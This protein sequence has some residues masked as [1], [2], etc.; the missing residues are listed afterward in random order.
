M[1]QQKIGQFLRELRK[2]K[3][4][5]QEQLLEVFGVTNRSISRWENGVNM[6]DFDLVMEI[7][8][9][10]DVSIDELLDGEK[11]SDM[12]DKQTKETLLKVAAYDNNEKFI[13]SRRMNRLF[14]IAILSFIVYA[15]LEIQGLTAIG[16]Y[17]NIASFTLGIILG[18]LI[19]GAIYTSRYIGK[20]QAFKLRLLNR[21]K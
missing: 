7:T 4:L 21:E 16:I 9:Y 2:E 3:G 12:I 8:D 14:L 17:G 13:F 19:T 10:F 6:P 1:N 11:K 5:T 15:I 20:I 18:T